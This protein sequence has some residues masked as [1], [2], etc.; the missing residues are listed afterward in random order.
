[1]TQTTPSSES[2]QSALDRTQM[3]L[4][5][6]SEQIADRFEQLARQ[7]RQ[8]LGAACKGGDTAEIQ[9]AS[10]ELTNQ[11]GNALA[12]LATSPLGDALATRIEYEQMLQAAQ[13]REAVHEVIDTEALPGPPPVVYATPLHRAMDEGLDKVLETS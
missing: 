7:I 12:G 4:F 13:L 10:V 2:I 9:R 5:Q 1:M 3:S 11:I 6:A 8:G